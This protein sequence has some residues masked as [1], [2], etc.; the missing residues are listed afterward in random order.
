MLVFPPDIGEGDQLYVRLLPVAVAATP[1]VVV[2]QVSIREV[3]D[4]LTLGTAASANTCEIAAAE[5]QPLAVFVTITVNTPVPEA[6]G[7]AMAV[8]FNEPVDGTCQ[9]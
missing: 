5:E 8:L 7:F 2:A 1:T 9:L 6:T 4:K 3:A